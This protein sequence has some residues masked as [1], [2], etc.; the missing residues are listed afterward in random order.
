[1]PP[2]K[3]LEIA[4]IYQRR[5]NHKDIENKQKTG[6]EEKIKTV[7]EWQNQGRNLL[8]ADGRIC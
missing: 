5:Q 4:R 8:R 7:K 3:I 2:I 6:K 1:M